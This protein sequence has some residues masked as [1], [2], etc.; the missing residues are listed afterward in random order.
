MNPIQKNPFSAI[1][2]NSNLGIGKLEKKHRFLKGIMIIIE[3]IKYSLT[4]N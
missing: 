4:N 3:F 2:A 1:C